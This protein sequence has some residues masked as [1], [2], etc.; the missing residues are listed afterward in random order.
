[1]LWTHLPG[2]YERYGW[3]PIVQETI[4]AFLPDEPA[5]PPDISPLGSDD[6]PEVV[7]LFELTNAQRSGTVLR[8]A[9]Y[10]RAQPAWLHLAPDDTLGLR[11]ADGSLAGYIR[12]RARQTDVEVLELGA[13]VE[14]IEVG[15]RLV[16]AAARKRSGRVEAQLPR[17]LASV[18]PPD[19]RQAVEDAGLMG[20]VLDTLRLLHVL[21]PVLE[22]RVEVAGLADNALYISTAAG[23]A[24]LRVQDGQLT[25]TGVEL[26]HTQALLSENDL[27]HLLFHGF[28]A[29]RFAGRSDAAMLRALFPAQ[30][31]V[32]WRADAF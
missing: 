8:S 11:R 14:E 3:T 10:W 7:R 17:S 4:R 18:I 31:F 26:D 32:I 6:L 27:G 29:E 24:E 9:E 5:L 28:D 22:R 19:T 20:R 21:R 13:P 2:L 15:T 12:S 25:I 16:K 30:D 1:L 23:A